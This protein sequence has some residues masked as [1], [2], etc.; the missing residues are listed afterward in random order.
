[1]AAITAAPA[2]SPFVWPRPGGIKRVPPLRA[3]QPQPQPVQ[4]APAAPVNKRISQIKFHEDLPR[5]PRP[6]ST[7]AL[8]IEP[9]PKP[10]GVWAK[11]ASL[12]ALLEPSPAVPTRRPLGEATNKS[13][14]QSAAA[15]GGAGGE[16]GD[17]AGWWQN[18]TW[19]DKLRH[20]LTVA[21]SKPSSGSTS[22][23][24]A[25]SQFIHPDAI[26]PPGLGLSPPSR[27]K[28]ADDATAV[29]SRWAR[30]SSRPRPASFPAAAA[31]NTAGFRPRV[32][33][34]Q[35]A[36]T[37]SESVSPNSSPRSV[38][39]TEGLP[40]LRHRLRSGGTVEIL[41]SPGQPVLVDLRQRS[42][43]AILISPASDTIAVFGQLTPGP[44]VLVNP[45]A[46]YARDEL[47]AAY[48]RIYSVAAKF[49]ES[50]RAKTPEVG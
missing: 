42:S 11:L 30:P 26:L 47:P 19:L 6:T 22:T 29:P 41:L 9:T 10:R 21:S 45:S 4:P 48:E 31:A 1:M 46:V 13:L 27:D 38:P 14:G 18:R 36:F 8:P 28:T 32:V 16:K 35:T 25:R 34:T 39:S 20:E 37:L 2:D 44:L 43:K 7:A 23:P 24:S 50:V 17:G 12:N 49:V 15:T 3:P 40:P 33:S 5:R